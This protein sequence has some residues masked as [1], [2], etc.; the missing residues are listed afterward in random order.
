MI[1]QQIYK[2]RLMSSKEAA[3][4]VQSGDFFCT[5]LALGQPSS[6]IM[7]D[8]ADRKEE[9]KDVE[10]WGNLVLRPYK[11]FRPEYR[12]TFTPISSF[13]NCQILQEIAKSEWDN[14]LTI[15][16]AD[17]GAKYMERKRTFPRRTGTII[18]VAPPDE[19]GFVNLGLDTCYTEEMMDH[20]DW[21]IAQVNPMMPRTYG[22][23]NFHVSR[24]SAFVE[25]EEPIMLLPM[26]EATEAEAKM[27]AFAVSLIKDRDCIQVGI[28]AIPAIIGNLLEHSNLRDLGIHTEM[29]P[30]QTHRLVEKGI[31]T[32]NYKKTNPGKIVSAFSLGD[33]DLYD[34]LEN[35]PLCEF[36][37]I[38]YCNRPSIIAQED[39]V[40][41]I[42]GCIEVDLTGQIVSESTGNLMRSGTHGQLDFAVGAFWSKGGRAINLVPSTTANDTASRIVP[43]LSTG[44]RV[45]VPGNYAGF[46]VTEYGIADLYGRTEQE[47][48][49]AL[50]NIAHPK[51]REDLE[52]SAREKGMIKKQ[53]F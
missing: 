40:V 8:I 19:H 13:Y 6:I 30:A 48:A 25:H 26:R 53:I 27:A 15:S 7:D 32:G 2:E 31:T 21:I 38:R 33:R 16:D 9:L 44:A 43:C 39:N 14:T 50:I 46:V 45:T 24:F 1:W 23:S 28:D 20:S 5:P 17:A 41:A 12:K 36:R 11:I 22:Q 51:F 37:P 34:F 47:K 10:Y 4:I 29:V 3:G 52:K 42:N 18:Q 35:N 49:T